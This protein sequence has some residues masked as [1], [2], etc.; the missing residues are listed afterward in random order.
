MNENI[1]NK[2][3]TKSKG[4]KNKKESKSVRYRIERMHCDIIKDEFWDA[5]PGLL[6]D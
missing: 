1:Q 6:R 5:R 3:L 2:K 4:K